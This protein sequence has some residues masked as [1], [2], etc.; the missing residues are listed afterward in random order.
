M[1]YAVSTIEVR[2]TVSKPIVLT[3][4]LINSYVYVLHTG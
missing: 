3:D 4:I 1:C 2:C